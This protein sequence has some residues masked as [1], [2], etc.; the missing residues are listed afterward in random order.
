MTQFNFCV[1]SLSLSYT[2]SFKTLHTRVD[3]KLIFEYIMSKM[4]IFMRLLGQ[5]DVYWMT[6][7]HPTLL[8]IELVFY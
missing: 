6:G 3:L 7:E 1:Y 2:V 4:Y 8:N 5:R